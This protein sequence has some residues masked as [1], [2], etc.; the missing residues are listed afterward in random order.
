[1]RAKLGVGAFLLVVAGTVVVYRLAVTAGRRVQA[2]ATDGESEAMKEIGELRAEVARL[3]GTVASQHLLTTRALANQPPAPA[4]SPVPAEGEPSDGV[5]APPGKRFPTHQEA[6]AQIDARFNGEP[7]HAAWGQQVAPL[8]TKVFRSRLPEGSSLTDVD[9][10]ETL[11]RVVMKHASMDTYRQLVE[12]TLGARDSG[13]WN[14][15]ISS[16][17]TEQSPTSVTTVTFIAREGMPVPAIENVD[18]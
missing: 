4:P 14:G 6:V 18:L 2:P 1:M 17:V 11:C 8:A 7:A 12:S 5:R 16:I 9:C 10:R 15:G 3:K 13:L